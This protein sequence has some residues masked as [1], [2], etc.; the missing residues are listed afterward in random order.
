MTPSKQTTSGFTL[1]EL[2]VV[3]AIIAIL[4]SLLLPALSKAKTQAKRA[5]C[6]NNQHQ[7]YLGW[8]MYSQENRGY[9]A[10]NDISG[11]VAPELPAWVAGQMCYE[12]DPPFKP[13][14]TDN[15]NTALIL[16]GKYG[17]IGPY[18]GGAKPYRCPADSSW[19]LLNGLRQARV[20]SY[21]MNI[22]LGWYSVS[23]IP[24]QGYKYFNREEDLNVSDQNRIFAFIDEHEDTIQ[25]GVFE[26]DMEP[27]FISVPGSRHGGGSVVTKTSGTVDFQ[28]WKDSRT[29]LPVEHKYVGPFESQGNPD[30]EWLKWHSTVPK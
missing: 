10:G 7:L 27:V 14:L 16:P 12:N 18:V 30:I 28:K 17:S 24:R 6:I 1:I 3:I 25:D 4:A 29:K 8:F 13:F 15:T 23:Q 21:S 26:F 2:L 5:S 20:R 11:G 22:F 9:I 19:V